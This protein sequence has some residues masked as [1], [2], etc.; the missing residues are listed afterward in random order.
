MLNQA[1]IARDGRPSP[2]VAGPNS[3]DGELLI[4]HDD[5]QTFIAFYTRSRKAQRL[6]PE[7][8]QK[9]KRISGQV[10]RRGAVTVLWTHP[11][12]SQLR[13]RVETCAFG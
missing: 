13:N 11:A 1:R 5:A 3:R 9:A 6:E 2:A 8:V 12:P 4:A 10:M 7:V